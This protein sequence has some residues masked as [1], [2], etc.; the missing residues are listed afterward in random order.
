[1]YTGIAVAEGPV[2]PL[3]PWPARPVDC[4]MEDSAHKHSCSGG[5]ELVK[6]GVAGVQGAS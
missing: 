2:G 4:R 5:E 6:G 1:V 3:V